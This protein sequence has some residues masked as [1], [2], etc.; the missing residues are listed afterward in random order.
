MDPSEGLVPD[1]PNNENDLHAGVQKVDAGPTTSRFLS[2]AD[3]FSRDINGSNDE[4]SNPKIKVG[5]TVR[6]NVF[7]AEERVRKYENPAEIPRLEATTSS[8]NSNTAERNE[9]DN[10]KSSNNDE[11][12][13]NNS[14]FNYSNRFGASNAI[15]H[16]HDASDS[17]SHSN[18]AS[19]DDTVGS[20]VSNPITF[21]GAG[22]TRTPSPSRSSSSWG[23]KSPPPSMSHSPSPPHRRHHIAV[24]AMSRST[25]KILQPHQRTPLF[26]QPDLE[27]ADAVAT[28]CTGAITSSTGG[29]TVS[30]NT[31]VLNT[32]SANNASA[33]TASQITANTSRQIPTSGL[34]ARVR[35]ITTTAA[36]EEGL[37]KY[38]RCVFS[39][40]AFMFA[41]LYRHVPM[42]PVER[43][44]LGPPKGLFHPLVKAF[45]GMYSVDSISRHIEYLRTAE[46]PEGR[47]LL[48]R[49]DGLKPLD[50]LANYSSL[51]KDDMLAIR[52]Y[53]D[54]GLGVYH[55][56]TAP[57]NSN[58]STVGCMSDLLLFMKQLHL[59]VEKIKPVRLPVA[60][61][62]LN[63]DRNEVLRRQ[64]NATIQY[65]NDN[66]SSNNTSSSSSASSTSAYSHVDAFKQK[67]LITFHAMTS[68]TDDKEVADKFG[69]YFCFEFLNV[70]ARPIRE[71]SVHQ[72]E[73]EYI[74]LPP[75]TFEVVQVIAVEVEDRKRHLTVRVKEVPQFASYFTNY[76]DAL[77]IPDNQLGAGIA[78][79][80]TKGNLSVETMDRMGLRNYLCNAL[81]AEKYCQALL[82]EDKPK[83]SK[84]E[85]YKVVLNI[86][87]IHTR[88]ILRTESRFDNTIVECSSLSTMADNAPAISRVPSD[89]SRLSN[90]AD[91]G[92]DIENI[93]VSSDALTGAAQTQVVAS[94]T[95]ASTS[96]V[97]G[98]AGV[99]LNLRGSAGN[100][101]GHST[102]PVN[103]SA[104]VQL[105]DTSKRRPSLPPMS[106]SARF[107]RQKDYQDE[108][109]DMDDDIP[110]LTGSECSQ[111]TWESGYVG[112]FVDSSAQDQ[113]I[114][115]LKHDDII[116]S[117]RICQIAC[118][119][120]TTHCPE[121]HSQFCE[122]G[123][124]QAIFA[125]LHRYSKMEKPVPNVVK[126]CMRAL[127]AARSL[128]K[129]D[130]V[131]A[132]FTEK[133]C[134][135]AFSVIMQY[136]DH[137]HLSIEGWEF[138]NNV[139]HG[140]WPMIQRCGHMAVKAVATALRQYKKD[141]SVTWPVLRCLLKFI[142]VK[143]LA[144]IFVKEEVHKIVFEI[145]ID[146]S[147]IPNFAGLQEIDKKTA[148]DIC[149]CSARALLFMTRACDE[150]KS[151]L[152]SSG[153]VAVMQRLQVAVP[154][155]LGDVPFIELIQAVV[156]THDF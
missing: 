62:G 18:I 150:V 127:E 5:A 102:F 31:A 84:Y 142:R 134:R 90:A 107:A 100:F 13:A 125:A 63:L 74:V 2:E 121:F 145:L 138:I 117:G 11:I 118:K 152:K 60:Y 39:R 92:L 15:S 58:Y 91:V 151:F 93:A 137:R 78:E 9:I 53:S 42:V 111:L 120:I 146:Q 85:G 67:A 97:G 141:N 70:T 130:E 77:T 155:M 19:N 45:S 55:M 8:N 105:P 10:I 126:L 109:E 132:V 71:Y 28:A 25:D 16:S 26:R 144:S 136:M 139:C 83:F 61:R 135:I 54:K 154:T 20:F 148:Q 143:Q 133:S 43:A 37:M 96:G 116:A 32:A 112:D 103:P 153:G 108:K 1:G 131:R 7:D 81:V 27:D 98:A 73:E 129:E 86:L 64:Y 49:H 75:A 76:C 38:R 95:Q 89:A 29:N 34:T 122:N 47:R 14:Q 119:V 24:A 128:A 106:S 79:R 80:L 65:L 41:S 88:R 3:K 17:M 51:D 101:E 21:S 124:C 104:S 30:S 46:M 23:A 115:E 36:A 149:K 110:S 52:V 22:L 12:N 72:N 33:V 147:N 6:A 114:V 59:A 94:A 68:I 82:N 113:D 44:L 123:A 40:T 35:G 66:S 48:A 99:P 69:K 87:D 57:L 140:M 4:I 156:G 56:I 50:A